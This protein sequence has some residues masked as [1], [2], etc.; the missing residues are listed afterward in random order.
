MRTF[1]YDRTGEAFLYVTGAGVLYD[2]QNRHLGLIQDEQVV[3]ADMAHLGWFDGDFLWS[4][5]GYLLGFVKGAK[6][7]GL[8]L[9]KT[10][11]LRF[12]P[13]PTPFAL[14]PLLT[15]R[16]KPDRKWQWSLQ[17]LTNLPKGEQA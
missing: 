15:S 1:I 10:K 3:T 17:T 12:R 7:E 9:P 6:C 5:N 11:P 13:Q 4:V 16:V 8:E 14:H 2:A